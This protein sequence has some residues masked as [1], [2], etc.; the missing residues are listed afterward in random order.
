MNPV[1][2]KSPP[3][4]PQEDDLLRTLS[5]SGASVRAIA[6][7]IGRSTSAVRNRAYWLKIA[8]AKSRFGLKEKK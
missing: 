1:A 6:E 8:V 4:M 2:R 3:W 7:K 5:L